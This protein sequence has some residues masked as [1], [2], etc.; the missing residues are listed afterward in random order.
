[1]KQKSKNRTTKMDLSKWELVSNIVFSGKTGI[2]LTKNYHQSMAT[3]CH[4]K[5]ERHL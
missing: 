1:M 4:L 3:W 2:S 5:K